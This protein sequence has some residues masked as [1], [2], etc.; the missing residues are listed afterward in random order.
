[1]LAAFLNIYDFFLCSLG[2]SKDAAGHENTRR[3]KAF[4][5]KLQMISTAH[6][7]GAS[8]VLD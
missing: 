4:L 2:S 5:F 7:A 8:G 1:M 3:T 6:I